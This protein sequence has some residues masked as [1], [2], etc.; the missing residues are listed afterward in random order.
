MVPIPKHVLF[1]AQK[2]IITQRFS[3][4]VNHKPIIFVLVNLNLLLN[5]IFYEQAKPVTTVITLICPPTLHNTTFPHNY[6][7]KTIAA[8]VICTL[9][10]DVCPLV[11]I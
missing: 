3:V 6:V 7:A 5:Q 8:S 9:V 11:Q 10:Y 1:M 2:H 4:S